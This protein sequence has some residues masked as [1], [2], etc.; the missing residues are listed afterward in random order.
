[1]DLGYANERVISVNKKT[2]VNNSLS[3]TRLIRRIRR[4]AIVSVTLMANLL[5]SVISH[6]TFFDLYNRKK[7]HEKATK[8]Q[9]KKA[10]LS[11]QKVE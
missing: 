7:K 9:V 4:P 5:A 8:S 2:N 11:F 3:L 6:F 10:G 1:V